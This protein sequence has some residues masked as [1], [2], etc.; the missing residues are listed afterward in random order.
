MINSNEKI[1]VSV[2]MIAYNHEKYIGEAIEGVLLQKVN[3]KIELIIG[4]DCSTDDTVA[5]IKEYQ[6]KFPNLIKARYNS[7]N[8]G[9]TPNA[10]KTFEE[11]TGKYIA[12]CEGDDYWT[13]PLKLQTQLDFLENHEEYVSCFHNSL[14]LIENAPE[15]SI[16][17]CTFNESRTFC[18]DDLLYSN[19]MPTQSVVFRR[20]LDFETYANELEKS[21]FLDWYLHLL[22]ARSGKVWYINE[23]MGVYRIN[24]SGI[25]STLPKVQ[26]LK[27]II[28]TYN[29]YKITFNDYHILLNR[30]QKKYIIKYLGIVINKKL[31]SEFRFVFA[32]ILKYFSISTML[33][34]LVNNFILN[35]KIY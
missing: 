25:W 19:I 33:K 9:M 32:I 14:E 26:Q 35:K 29:L 22:N 4:D 12:M 27:N 13:D 20:S 24:T 30:I 3:F 23:V 17:Y 16:N 8:M 10:L 1:M 31:Y 2:W 11:C 6:K 34:Y 7:S 5:I 15:R 18:F 21:K 28:D